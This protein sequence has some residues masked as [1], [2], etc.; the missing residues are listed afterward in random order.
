MNIGYKI[1]HRN[2]IVKLHGEL[3][4]HIAEDV[5]E[6]ID[7]AIE[8]NSIKNVI[9][10]FKDINF[11]DSSGVGVVI[12]RYRKVSKTGGKVVAINLNKHVKRI[13]DLSGM[14][15]IIGVY[16]NYEEAKASL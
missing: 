7:I 10:D 9:F 6:E 5:R 8:Q 13:F 16:N 15:K 12:G 4:H 14:N 2:L 1:D 11:M 3:D